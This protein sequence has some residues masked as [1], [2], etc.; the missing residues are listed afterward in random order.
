V[1]IQRLLGALI[2]ESPAR[3]A[4]EQLRLADAW[5]RYLRELPEQQPAD[6]KQSRPSK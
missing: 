6:P 5:R 4:G 1:S 2:P 3:T